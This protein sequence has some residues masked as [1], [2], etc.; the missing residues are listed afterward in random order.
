MKRVVALI[1]FAMAALSTLPCASQENLFSAWE[2]RVRSTSAMQPGWATPVIT[3]SSGIVQL[4]RPEL[5]QSYTPTHYVTVNYGNSKGFDFIPYYKTQVDVYLPPYIVHNNPNVR[6]GAGDFSMAAKY[7]LF[8]ANEK[9]GNYSTALQLLWTLP[10]GSYKNGAKHASLTPTFVGGKGFGIFDVQSSMGSQLP[11]E[12]A[13]VTGRTISS[14][15]A[16]QCKLAKIYWPEIEVNSTF[17]L[18]GPNDGKNQTFIT[19]GLMINK[20]KL[21]HEA[22]NR[23]AL[24][25][26]AGM[27]IA[28]SHFHTYNH[29]LVLTSRIAF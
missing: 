16:A 29:N 4:V 18:G 27:Q 25:F 12:G 13:D 5:T 6:D 17:Y 21:S 2:N 28:T 3:T 9:H 15:T 14:N 20:I 26:G 23:L 1:T 11:V 22:N 24:I 19:P 7:R 10:T 8:A